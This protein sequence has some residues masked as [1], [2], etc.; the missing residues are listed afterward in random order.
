MNEKIAITNS[1][2]TRWWW[3]RHAPVTQNQERLYGSSDISA[4]INAP[5]TFKALALLLPN[6]A[7]CVRSDLHRTQQTLDAVIA[8]GLDA[9]EPF[10]ESDLAEQNFGDW[11]GQPYA[12]KYPR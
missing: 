11:H 1:P 8:A 6:G 5:E 7:V 4:E 12:E 10:V 3:I 2:I 9:S